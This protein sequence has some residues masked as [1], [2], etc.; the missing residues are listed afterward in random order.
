MRRNRQAPA[1][2]FWVKRLYAIRTVSCPLAMEL[3]D[4]LVVL[5]IVLGSA[6]GVDHARH[7]ESFTSRM[8]WAGEFF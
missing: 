5:G 1:W 4:D 2:A 7:A 3:L 6:A 8:K